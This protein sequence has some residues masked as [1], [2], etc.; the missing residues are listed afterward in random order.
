MKQDVQKILLEVCVISE[1]VP[2][3]NECVFL[4]HLSSSECTKDVQD[5]DDLSRMFTESELR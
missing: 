4:R 2:D 3:R 5:V 1:R